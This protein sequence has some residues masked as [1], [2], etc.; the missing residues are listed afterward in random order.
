MA[1]VRD[2]A[3]L[4]KLLENFEKL[5]DF[6]KGKYHALELR[7]DAADEHE[8]YIGKWEAVRDELVH[9]LGYDES[10]GAVSGGRYSYVKDTPGLAD[11][12]KQI[13][14]FDFQQ[15]LEDQKKNVAVFGRLLGVDG[16]ADSLLGRIIKYV[17]DKANSAERGELLPAYITEADALAKYLGKELL[18][19]TLSPEEETDVARLGAEA[20]IKALDILTPLL[21]GIT[22][23]RKELKNMLQYFLISVT[24]WAPYDKDTDPDIVARTSLSTDAQAKLSRWESYLGEGYGQ[25]LADLQAQVEGATNLGNAIAESVMVNIAERATGKQN[26]LGNAVVLTL[27]D[28]SGNPVEYTRRD[29]YKLFP[30]FEEQIDYFAAEITS[31]VAQKENE[32]RQLGRQDRQKEVDELTARVEQWSLGARL[33]RWRQKSK[34]KKA[35]GNDKLYV[36]RFMESGASYAVRLARPIIAGLRR[37]YDAFISRARDSTRMTKSEI[38]T[39]VAELETQYWHKAKLAVDKLSG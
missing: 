14:E 25:R 20:K 21:K 5:L 12:V 15:P 8:E 2:A 7:M 10:T 28:G 38:D 4:E 32:A 31:Y 22:S 35:Q 39:R 9:S 24:G 37:Q 11:I 18:G 3:T 16:G 33:K 27:P 36:E 34:L 29:A 23:E 26:T 13:A 30:G 6:Y 19:L 1:K 17:E